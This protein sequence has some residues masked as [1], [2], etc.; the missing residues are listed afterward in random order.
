MFSI[1]V[2]FSII[3]MVFLFL[4]FLL[5]NVYKENMTFLSLHPQQN[6]CNWQI[7]WSDLPAK[8]YTRKL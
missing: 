8:N 5:N 2:G 4:K 6:G 1:F 7:Q 3:Q